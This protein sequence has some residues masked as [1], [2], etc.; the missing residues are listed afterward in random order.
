MSLARLPGMQ[1]KAERPH[2]TRAQAAMHHVE[3][4]FLLGHEQ[5]APPQ[6][7]VMDDKVGDR[8]AL[9]GSGR[10]VQDKRLFHRR[11]ENGRKLRSIGAKR[12]KE[13]GGIYV[14]R[15]VLRRE[16][17]NTV[18]IRAAAG[19]QMIHERMAAQLVQPVGKIFP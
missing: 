7:K 4:G 14:P 17:R 16:N 1:F 10:T 5:D 11:I 13:I 8:L 12:T 2:T 18:I 3:R 6:R 15:N 9:A 19:D